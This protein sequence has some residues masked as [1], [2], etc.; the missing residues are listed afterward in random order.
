MTTGIAPRI[1]FSEDLARVMSEDDPGG[2]RSTVPGI[3]VEVA[4]GST[5]CGGTVWTKNAG[6]ATTRRNMRNFT[7][8][9]A[10]LDMMAYRTREME[11]QR[12]TWA[13]RPRAV[14]AQGTLR[15]QQAKYDEISTELLNLSA[16]EMNRGEGLST[17]LTLLAS[18]MEEQRSIIE[19][20]QDFRLWS[21]LET[22]MI[23][24]SGLSTSRERFNEGFWDGKWRFVHWNGVRFEPRAN[25]P[26][27]GDLALGDVY[28]V[29]VQ[30]TVTGK[31][32]KIRVDALV[33]KE[34]LGDWT[35]GLNPHTGDSLEVA[36]VQPII[37]EEVVAAPAAPSG[38]SAPT[39]AAKAPPEPSGVIIK[40]LNEVARE[41]ADEP[42]ASPEPPDSNAAKSL[43]RPP[44][45]ICGCGQEVQVLGNPTHEK[46]KRHTRWAAKQE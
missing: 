32:R 23:L 12:S 9:H 34:R 38:F 43:L 11:Q 7:L 17:K 16:G 25:V 41:D 6:P 10:A 28:L 4:T 8:I 2:L 21:S 19:N 39:D 44:M 13:Q 15:S 5:A 24:S 40:R 45:E 46:G 22:N 3:P 20:R 42:P 29:A 35:K 26:G 1:E 30:E 31:S 18:D 36:K 14:I 27:W 37:E 33:W